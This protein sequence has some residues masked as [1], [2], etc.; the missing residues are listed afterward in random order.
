MLVTIARDTDETDLLMVIL[1]PGNIANLQ[2]G[3]PIGVNISPLHAITKVAIAY[4][5]DIE[6]LVQ[7]LQAGGP[8][9]TFPFLASKIEASL[10]RK[11][12]FRAAPHKITFPE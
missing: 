6:W 11:P 2:E 1:E 5:P 7:E 4:T 10:K 3:M 9:V 12:V 8:F